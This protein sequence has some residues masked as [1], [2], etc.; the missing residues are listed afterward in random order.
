M[1]NYP[2]ISVMKQK[3]GHIAPAIGALTLAN[4]INWNK[5]P[6]VVRASDNE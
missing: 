5:I 4:E 6:D 1:L 2:K 3:D